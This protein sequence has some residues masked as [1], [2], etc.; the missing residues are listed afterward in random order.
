MA[1]VGN[2]EVVASDDL[3]TLVPFGDANRLADA[4]GEALNRDWDR[5]RIMQY[6]RENA[7]E[8]RVAALH[9]HFRELAEVLAALK[10]RRGP[11]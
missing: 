1:A 8:R 9:A 6:A 2:D 11:A 7:W 5:E 3:G 4:I 10:G